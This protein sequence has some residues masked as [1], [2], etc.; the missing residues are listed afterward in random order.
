RGARHANA[1]RRN[2]DTPAFEPRERDPVAFAWR[3]DQVR[4]RHAAVFE[5]DLRRI[6]RVLAELVLDS[7]D[8][9]AFGIGGHDERA[10]AALARRPVGYGHHDRDVAVLAARDELFDAVQHVRVAVAR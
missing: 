8:H 3:A 5:N 4:R 6:R 2:A 7:R 10:D 1:L 9:V